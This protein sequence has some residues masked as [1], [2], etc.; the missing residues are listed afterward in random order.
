MHYIW[1]YDFITEVIKCRQHN[2]MASMLD[3][4]SVQQLKRVRHA[5]SSLSWF[6]VSAAH[7]DC[8]LPLVDTQV[9]EVVDIHPLQGTSHSTMKPGEEDNR[10][11][12]CTDSTVFKVSKW[13][14]THHILLMDHTVLCSM[15]LLLHSGRST[16]Y[17]ILNISNNHKQS[18]TEGTVTAQTMTNWVSTFCSRTGHEAHGQSRTDE[19]HTG[20]VYKC[21]PYTG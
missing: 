5:E 15:F 13:R 16:T 6:R 21:S 20:S 19:K 12:S 18:E 10:E 1:I 14:T 3:S 4:A 8:D 7:H 2:S 9:Q 11:P 17:G